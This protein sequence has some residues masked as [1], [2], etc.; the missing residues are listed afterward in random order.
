MQNIK[1]DN[2]RIA[3]NTAFLYVRMLF[4]LLVSLYTT[5]VVLQILGVEDYG[6]Y[7]V[8]GGFV[9]MFGFLNTSLAGAIQ[10]F[11]NYE[12]TKQGAEGIQKVYITSLIIQGMIS[13]VLLLVL[14]SFGLWY[15]NNV[16]VVST[17]KIHAANILFQCSVL[18]MLLVIMQIPYSAAVMSFERMDFYAIVG[19]IDV[20]LKL[21]IVV[22]LPFVPYD[23][24]I[25][26][27]V[28]IFFVSL[29]NF[30]LYFAYVRKHFVE[31]SLRCVFC[32][33]LS[34]L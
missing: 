33:E 10:R 25:T 18:S 23:K 24:L 11:Y 7:N 17:D 34:P 27:G 8:V 15:V 20:F 26:Y 28:L 13:V 32:K 5:R 1:V 12:V 22:V 29:V 4:V 16:L 6:V 31:M 30:F 3:K 2:K 21:A 9:S 19:I 14:E